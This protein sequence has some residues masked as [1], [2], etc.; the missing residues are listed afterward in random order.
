[1]SNDEPLFYEKLMGLRNYL[2]SL[3]INEDGSSLYMSTDGVVENDIQSKP[4]NVNDLKN[5]RSY[6]GRIFYLKN[7]LQLLGQG[8]SRMVF[9]I[10]GKKVIK[11]AKN[12]KGIAQNFLEAEIGQDYYY[13]DVVTEVFEYDPDFVWLIS[14]YASKFT[15]AEFKKIEQL[16][17]KELK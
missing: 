8:S 14:E 3:G 10:D 17:A 2:N 16:L 5:I 4:F 11:V 7:K 9:N 15:E 13:K 6:K 1:M 12:A